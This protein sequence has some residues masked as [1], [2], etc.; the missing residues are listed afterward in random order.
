MIFAKILFWSN[1][2]KNPNTTIKIYRIMSITIVAELEYITAVLQVASIKL[3]WYCL[4][5][6]DQF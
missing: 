6:K 4:V 2:Q 3:F 5:E 1:S